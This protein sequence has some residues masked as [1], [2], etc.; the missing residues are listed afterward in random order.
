MEE[1]KPLDDINTK[2]DEDAFKMLC[3]SKI[4]YFWPPLNMSQNIQCP[5]TNSVALGKEGPDSWVA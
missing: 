4:L 1:I 2:I 3:M 5:A